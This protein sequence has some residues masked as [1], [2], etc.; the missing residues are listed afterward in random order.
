MR[1]HEKF[2]TFE[3]FGVGWRRLRLRGSLMLAIGALLA[4]ASLF[5]PKLTIMHGDDFSLLPLSGIVLLA[6]GLLESFDAYIA[7]ESKDFFLSL[8]NAILDVVVAI[9]IIFSL[10]DKPEKLAPL[11]AA[12]LIIKGIYRTI[13]TYA[14]PSTNGT[15]ARITAGISIFLGLLVWREWP[16]SAGYILAFCLSAEIAMR[17]WA[18]LKFADVLMAQEAQEYTNP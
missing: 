3:I 10:G 4:F 18:L 16:S 17:G 15:S 1:F 9:L 7:K 13:I 11:I 12:F 5:N 14:M 8:Q 6:V 2:T